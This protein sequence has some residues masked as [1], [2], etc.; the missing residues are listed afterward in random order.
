MFFY[1]AVKGTNGM[2]C[3]EAVTG[4]ISLS[5]KKKILCKT[6]TLRIEKNVFLFYRLTNCIFY[7]VLPVDQQIKLISPYSKNYASREILTFF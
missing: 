3:S 1:F 6:Q 5:T 2:E 4:F 7:V